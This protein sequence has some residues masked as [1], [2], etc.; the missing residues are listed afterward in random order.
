MLFHGP[1]TSSWSLYFE[2]L[3]C[4]HDTRENL[5]MPQNIYTLFSFDI[6]ST[7]KT[8]SSYYPIIALAPTCSVLLLLGAQ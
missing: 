4:S 1:P 2:P 3:Y 8:N 7:G 6:F 5:T